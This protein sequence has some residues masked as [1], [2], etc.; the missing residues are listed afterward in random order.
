M[1]RKI[2]ILCTSIIS[3]IKILQTLDKNTHNKILDVNKVFFFSISSTFYAAC[4]ESD[5][6]FL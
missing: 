6:R 4:H 3:N 2:E 5:S 1:I